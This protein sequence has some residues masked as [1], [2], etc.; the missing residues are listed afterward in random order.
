MGWIEAWRR[1]HWEACERLVS[2]QEGPP[3]CPIGPPA[4]KPVTKP[5]ANGRRGAEAE[6]VARKGLPNKGGRPALGDKAMTNA[7]RMRRYRARKQVSKT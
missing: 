4:E 6:L 2:E 7:E 5:D 3:P 1:L